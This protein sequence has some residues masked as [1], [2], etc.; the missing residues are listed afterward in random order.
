MSDL[1]LRH[2]AALHCVGYRQSQHTATQAMQSRSAV[3]RD[4][5]FMRLLFT[6]VNL[7]LATSAAK[8]RRFTIKHDRFVVEDGQ[9]SPVQIIAGEIHYARILPEYWEDRLMRLRSMGFNTIQVRDV[10]C[11]PPHTHT[12]HT[13]TTLMCTP[14]TYVPW[15]WHCPSPGV[16]GWTGSRDVE[17]FI[18]LAQDLGLL[19]LLRPGPYICAEWDFGGLPWWLGASSVLGGGNMT[20]RSADPVFLHHVD[21]CAT[22]CLSRAVLC[23]TAVSQLLG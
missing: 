12:Q 20:L 22:W 6:I 23:I 14:Q 3:N 9:T 1:R 2:C 10:A 8:P 15:N 21:R 7:V 18:R 13:T 11:A 5:C 17:A 16:C 19:V 4:P